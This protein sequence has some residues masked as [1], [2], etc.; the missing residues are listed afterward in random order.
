MSS[1]CSSCGALRTSHVAFKSPFSKASTLSI[2]HMRG[3]VRV[4]PSWMR[5]GASWMRVDAAGAAAVAS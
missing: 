5:V 2:S 1:S 3:M 4:G